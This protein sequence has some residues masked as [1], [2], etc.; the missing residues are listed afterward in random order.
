MA[1]RRI[2]ASSSGDTWDLDRDDATGRIAVVHT[3]NPASG[4][5]VAAFDLEAFLP[6]ARC[7]AEHAALMEM[8][9]TLIDPAA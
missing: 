6:R 8:I 7:S 5:A 1:R 9:G 3:A 2:Y 4:G